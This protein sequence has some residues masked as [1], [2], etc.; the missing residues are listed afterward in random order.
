MASDPDYPTRFL[1]SSSTTAGSASVE[2]SPRLSMSC[3]AILRKIRRM[4]LPERVFGSAG[5]NWIKSGVAIGEIAVPHM[6]DQFLAQSFAA[7][8]PSIQRDKDINA[9][10][11]DIM[12][13]ADNGGFGHGRHAQR[14]ALSISAVLK[15]CPATFRTSSTRPVIQ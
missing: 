9:L 5:A 2:M 13:T 8:L 6:G 1:T 11:F 3:A 15:R 7:C 4:I 10:P 12:R 14:K